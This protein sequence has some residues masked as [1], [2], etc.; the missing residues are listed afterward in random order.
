MKKNNIITLRLSDDELG[1]LGALCR[2]S[3]RS[4]SE[5]IRSLIMVGTV[6]ERITKE[7]LTI[8]RQLIGESTNLNQ[9][10]KQANTY[11]FL[12]I[13]EECQSMAKT[14]TQLINRL[15]DDR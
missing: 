2:R 5:T 9:L 7:H 1:W 8:I 12:T 14:I 6:R 15:K 3:K 4:K 10:A 11:G 13:S